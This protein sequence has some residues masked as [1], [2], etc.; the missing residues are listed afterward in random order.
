MIAPSGADSRAITRLEQVALAAS[1]DLARSDAKTATLL[2]VLTAGLSVISLT[3]SGRH[4]PLGSAL[5]LWLADATLGGALVMLLLTILPNLTG[6]T[7]WL[8]Y[9][10]LSARQALERAAGADESATAAAA[11]HAVRLADLARRKF[12]RQRAAIFLIFGAGGWLALALLA[13]IRT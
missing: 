2:G 9:A 13:N 8:G 1:G 6:G 5:C 3:G 4:L 12:A 10:D 11:E 7:G